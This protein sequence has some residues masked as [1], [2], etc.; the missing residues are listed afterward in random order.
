MSPLRTQDRLDELEREID[1][2]RLEVVARER[3]AGELLDGEE[4]SERANRIVAATHMLLRAK[5]DLHYD[6]SKASRAGRCPVH[7]DALI[8]V[9]PDCCKAWNFQYARV[10]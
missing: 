10:V 6:K 2:L 4:T 9:C 3:E 1:R 7:D 8:V 5:L